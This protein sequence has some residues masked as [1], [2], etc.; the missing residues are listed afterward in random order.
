MATGPYLNPIYSRSQIDNDGRRPE[1]GRKC[2]VNTARNRKAIEKRI[3]RNPRVSMRQIVRDMGISDRSV[4]RIAKTELG[5]KP[6]KLQ[7]SELLTEKK[8]KSYGSED[9]ENF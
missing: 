9:A 6:Y 2:I 1:S 5:L 3:Q 8:T 7:K 4:R